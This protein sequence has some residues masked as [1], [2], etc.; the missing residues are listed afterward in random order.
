MGEL[1]QIPGQNMHCIGAYLA[2]SA[3]GA[4][5]GVV[6]VQEVFGVNAH[7][8]AVVDRFAEQGYDTIAPAIFDF[9]ETGVEL[10]YSKTGVERGRQLAAEVGFDRA[11]AAVASAAE[12]IA[13]A[14]QTA[15][16]GYCWGGTVAFLANTRLGLPAV[17]YYGGRSVSFLHER[18]RA[19]LLIHVGAYDPIIPPADIERHRAA[20]PE[21]QI[22]VYEAGHGFNC[23]QRSDYDAKA[24]ALALQ[25]TLDFLAR[26]LT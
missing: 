5:G 20:L 18:P 15:V 13:F 7:I 24:A 26:T 11:V 23:D 8:R 12:S 25:R 3:R 4:H 2:R 21:A 14:G 9:V 6:V 10:D 17:D 22:H 16:V 19:P 1:I